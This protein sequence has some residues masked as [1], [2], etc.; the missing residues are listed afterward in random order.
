MKPLV[1]IIIPCYR[2]GRY[3]AE[4]IESALAQSY[5]EVQVIVVNDGSDDDTDAVA[6]RYADRIC[7][8][9]QPNRGV[10]VA[11]NAG[12]AAARGDYLLFLD[13]DDL[14]RPDAVRQLIAAA[15]GEERVVVQGW[16]CFGD[17]VLHLDPTEHLPFLDGGPLPLLLHRIPAQPP[18]AY[19]CPARPARQVGGFAPE[20][21]AS[22]DWDLWLRLALA[23]IAWRA[24]P[25]VGARYRRHAGAVSGQTTKILQGRIDALLRAHR[26]IVTD[27][28]RLRQLGPELYQSQRDALRKVIARRHVDPRRVAALEGAIRELKQLGAAGYASWH[29]QAFSRLFGLRAER[30]R[31]LY[32]RL[33]RPQV[34]RA[35]ASRPV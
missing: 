35:M 28:A 18:A 34:F 5:T 8:I 14:L 2:Q 24:V 13:A 27:P 17:N 23:G 33:L 19:L 21:T 11:R 7:Y 6:G 4:A 10:S 15:Q 26:A 3:L 31:V 30:L 25:Y 9:A 12:M 29:E 1:S 32:W 20:L 22:E 16:Q